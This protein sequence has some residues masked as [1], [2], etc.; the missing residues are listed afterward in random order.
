MIWS[1]ITRALGL[2]EGGAVRGAFEQAWTALGLDRLSEPTPVHQRAAFTMAFI[3]LAAKM[4]KADGVAVPLEAEAF[5][6]C[7]HVPP[8][9]HANVKRLFDLAKADTAGYEHY[10]HS[11][12]QL[13]GGDPD[14]VHELFS[15]LF[16]IAAADGILHPAEERYLKNVAAHLG[17]S[18]HEYLEVRRLFVRDEDNPFVILDLEPTASLEVVKAR[19][20]AL[21]QE[22]H[23]DRL[24]AH[25][26]PE[27]FLAAAESKLKRINAAYNQIVREHQERIAREPAS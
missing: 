16:N 9:E 13:M 26:V 27:E 5:E 3:A 4:A 21:A 6:R 23:P 14:L 19:Y 8:E 25:G 11:I 12:G 15:C 18:L 1:T 7:Y 2:A 20:R 10:A 17:M 22:H 24:A